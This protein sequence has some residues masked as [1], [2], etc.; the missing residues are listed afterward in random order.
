MRDRPVLIWRKIHAR[1]GHDCRWCQAE[2]A[3]LHALG[4]H[5]IKRK[6]CT[7]AAINPRM[8]SVGE[9]DIGHRRIGGQ[10]GTKARCFATPPPDRLGPTPCVIVVGP[11]QKMQAIVEQLQTWVD[12]PR[13]DGKRIGFS[14]RT[15]IEQ[16]SDH[17]RAPS[18]PRP[19]KYVNR[20]GSTDFHDFDALARPQRGDRVG[21]SKQYPAPQHRKSNVG[22]LGQARRNGERG[23]HA[24]PGWLDSQPRR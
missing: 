15:W 21:G 7:R 3:Q 18:T 11:Q 5:H 23:A 14:Y 24:P 17:D 20:V 10:Q 6:L 19:V 8:S 2:P 22:H 12:P 16:Q 9:D 1:P 13:L 4:V